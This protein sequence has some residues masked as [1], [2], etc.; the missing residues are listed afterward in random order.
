MM[1]TFEPEAAGI[2]TAVHCERLYIMKHP[3]SFNAMHISFFVLVT[4]KVLLAK[5]SQSLSLNL[6]LASALLRY[7]ILV[8]KLVCAF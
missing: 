3:V 4:L 2:N 1:M 6:L 5:Y 7:T 8:H